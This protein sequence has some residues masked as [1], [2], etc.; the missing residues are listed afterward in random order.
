MESSDI[1]VGV[2]KRCNI[3]PALVVALSAVVVL[4][5]GG[6]AKLSLAA[7]PFLDFGAFLLTAR[8]RARGRVVVVAAGSCVC[9]S[10]TVAV[11]TSAGL[12][13]AG[14]SSVV[15]KF[16]VPMPEMA[17]LRFRVA[18]HLFFT[19]LSVLPGSNFAISAQQVPNRWTAASTIWSSSAVHGSFRT[20]GSS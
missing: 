12:F 5:P 11:L 4:M 10:P 3:L 19:A 9:V 13:N 6:R 17:H 20:F 16:L 7:P 15:P 1:C 2:D 14:E 8:F 18:F